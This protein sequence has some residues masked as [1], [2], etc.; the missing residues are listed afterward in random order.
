MRKKGFF[1]GSKKANAITDTIMV[2]VFLFGFA[3]FSTTA[4]VI[5]NSVQAD[6]I[7]SVDGAE[8]K[9][10]ATDIGTN[11]P[12]WFDGAFIMAFILLWLFV[13]PSYPINL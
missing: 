8:A 11:Y 2:I 4:Y 3:M 12:L 9:Q 10:V 13:Y 7:D 5:F 6:L 1:R